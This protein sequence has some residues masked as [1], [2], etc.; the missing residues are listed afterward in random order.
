MLDKYLSLISCAGVLKVIY[1]ILG[2][3][4]HSLKVSGWM[5]RFFRIVSELNLVNRMHKHILSSC[6][7]A[8]S[9]SLSTQPMELL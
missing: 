1:N 3:S 9:F 7:I 6:S 5:L 4:T 2:Y 8:L